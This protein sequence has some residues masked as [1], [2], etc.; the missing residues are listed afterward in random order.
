MLS[1]GEPPTALFTADNVMT[2]GAYRAIREK[3][4]RI[5]DDISLFAYDDMDWLVFV[6]PAV[7]AVYQPVYEMGAKAASALIARLK[8]GDREPQTLF[9]STE[10]KIRQSVKTIGAKGVS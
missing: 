5:P 9:V 6:E 2:L 1:L 3:G 8:D 10:L 7:S 4:L